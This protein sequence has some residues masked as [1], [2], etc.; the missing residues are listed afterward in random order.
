MLCSV[1]NCV[2]PVMLGDMCI[3]HYTDTKLKSKRQAATT[4][5]RRPPLLIDVEPGV[6]GVPLTKG[7]IALIDEKD[8]NFIGQFIWSAGVAGYPVRN[9]NGIVTPMHVELLGKAPDGLVTDHI[10]RNPLNNQRNN[11]RF[12]TQRQN[13]FNS[14]RQFTAKGVYYKSSNRKYRAYLLIPMKQPKYLGMFLTEKE[15]LDC[16]A[17]EKSKILA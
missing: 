8:A 13:T 6:K 3:L 14:S 10:D 17:K 7:L 4:T 15:A 12:I 11:L 16:V 5:R 9:K 1:L 2:K